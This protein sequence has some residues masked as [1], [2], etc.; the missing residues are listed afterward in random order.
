[1]MYIEVDTWQY[2]FSICNSARSSTKIIDLKT[3]ELD[4][5]FKEFNVLHTDGVSGKLKAARMARAASA[6]S[7]MGGKIII[8]RKN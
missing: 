4:P 5:V 7:F 2:V 6:G 3:E 1:M 8:S